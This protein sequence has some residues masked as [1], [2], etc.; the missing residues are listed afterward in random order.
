MQDQFGHRHRTLGAKEDVQALAVRIRDLLTNEEA[1]RAVVDEYHPADI[2]EAM[3]Y[4]S[5]E[6]DLA[7][8]QHLNPVE[9]A[10]VLDEVDETTLEALA[11][12]TPPDRMAEILGHLSAD[13]AADVL[14]VLPEE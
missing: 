4:L 8:F 2:A 9:Q 3:R 1:L 7:L 14:G 13:E 11:E 6:E 10:E 12:A 5:D